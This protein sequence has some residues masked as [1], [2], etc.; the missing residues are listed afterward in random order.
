MEFKENAD[1]VSVEAQNNGVGM[2]QIVDMLKSLMPV[3]DEMKD[4]VEQTSNK[5]PKASEQLSTVTQ[6]TENATMEIL[7]ILDDMGM[8]IE[9]I[10]GELKFIYRDLMEKSNHFKI[11]DTMYGDMPESQQK[12]LQPFRH[13]WKSVETIAMHRDKIPMFVEKLESVRAVSMNIAMAL[14]VQ[15]ITSQQ[16]EGVRH[17]IENVQSRLTHIVGRYEGTE[18]QKYEEIPVNKS[19]DEHAT[20]V[21]DSS[22]QDEADSIIAQFTQNNERNRAQP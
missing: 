22:K 2:H 9:S 21:K 14:Q 8:R 16:I 13:H 6:A 12:I 4:A 11:L 17:M 20:Y 15:D 10:E 1:T 5:M 7:N 18:N 19:F 3:L